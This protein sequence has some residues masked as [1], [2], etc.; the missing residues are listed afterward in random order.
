MIKL[1]EK[2]IKEKSKSCLKLYFEKILI[3]IKLKFHK[4]K[5]I[6]KLKKCLFKIHLFLDLKKQSKKYI[7]SKFNLQIENIKTF[8]NFLPKKFKMKKLKKKFLIFQKIKKKFLNFFFDYFY[9][10]YFYSNFSNSN[11]IIYD[12]NIFEKIISKKYPIFFNFFQKSLNKL[13]NFSHF[14]KELF[15]TKGKFSLRR[16][17]CQN[18][19]KTI[20]FEF[21][22]FLDKEV[23][24][25]KFLKLLY[26]I[27]NSKI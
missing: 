2:I 11:V 7:E 27:F 26:I 24:E 23:K 19:C 17:F 9:S 22:V 6:F 15:K 3:L 14:S 1:K 10:V 18:T 25:E 4:T 13:K 21:F 8:N 16:K 20:K 5:L 12:K